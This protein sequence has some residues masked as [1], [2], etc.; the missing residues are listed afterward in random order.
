VF[1][2]INLLKIGLFHQKYQNNK[3]ATILHFLFGKRGATQCG[4]SEGKWLE[5][6]EYIK[7]I[8]SMALTKK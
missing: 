2:K 1:L 3:T 5:K 7:N 8:S 4:L 6:V